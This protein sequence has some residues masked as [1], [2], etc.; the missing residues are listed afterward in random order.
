MSEEQ[1]PTG[2]SRAHRLFHYCAFGHPAKK[3]MPFWTSMQD[4]RPSLPLNVNPQE[5]QVMSMWQWCVCRMGAWNTVARMFNHFIKIPRNPADG[6]RCEDAFRQFKECDASAMDRRVPTA[7]NEFTSTAHS[8][9]L[10]CRL[11]EYEAGVREARPQLRTWHW[12]LM[13]TETSPRGNSNRPHK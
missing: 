1:C 12:I 5:T 3:L 10:V 13:T 7:C 2:L 4:Y 8:D 6:F 9:W 11:A